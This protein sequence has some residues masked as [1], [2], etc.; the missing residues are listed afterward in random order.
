MEKNEFQVTIPELSLMAIRDQVVEQCHEKLKYVEVENGFYAYDDAKFVI[1][2]TLALR[3]VEKGID[4]FKMHLLHEKLVKACYDNVEIV[5]ENGIVVSSDEVRR[6]FF[7]EVKKLEVVERLLRSIRYNKKIAVSK[8][9]F[10]RFPNLLVTPCGIIKLKNGK[11]IKNTPRIPVTR[12]TDVCFDAKAEGSFF[13]KFLS[14]VTLANQELIEFL[15]IFFG[16][17]AT[18]LTDQEIIVVFYGDGRNGKSKLLRI[19]FEVLGNYAFYAS[20]NTFYAG[21]NTH[22]TSTMNLMNKR[23]VIAPEFNGKDRIDLNLLKSL[24]GRDI[25]T[26]QRKLF[27]FLFLHPTLSV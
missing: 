10:D 1:S 3:N 6:F 15:Q 17:C 26:L 4:Y 16:Y 19:I 18:G 5:T 12:C 7:H 2:N 23:L 21:S 27:V 14:D 25:I 13:K 24:S 20:K 22:P 8:E 11:I 9:Y